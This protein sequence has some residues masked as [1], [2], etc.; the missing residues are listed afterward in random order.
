MNDGV[1]SIIHDPFRILVVEDVS[2]YP[3]DTTAGRPDQFLISGKTMM[4]VRPDLGV[5]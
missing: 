4:R 3:N 1:T 2:G 5:L